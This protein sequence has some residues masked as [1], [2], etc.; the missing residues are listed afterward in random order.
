MFSSTSYKKLVKNKW[1]VLLVVLALALMA[2]QLFKKVLNRAPHEGFTQDSP[3]VSKHNADIYDSYYAMIYD[4]IYK[5][6]Q[7]VAY[8][9]Q[10]IIDMTHPSPGNSVF[11]DVGSGTGALVNE[12]TAQGYEAHG[13]DKSQAM[14][15]VA[16]IKYPDAA[17]N[18]KCG[19]AK[20]SMSFDRASFTHITCM[21][22]TLYEMDSESRATFFRNCYHWLVPN[23]YL[24]IHLVDRDT[25]SPIVPGAIPPTIENPQKYAKK[26]ITDSAIDFYDFKYKNSTKF[27][28]NGEVLIKE[29]F[30]DAKNG[31]IRENEM[32]LK[33]DSMKDIMFLAQ[34]CGFIPHSQ[35][36]YTTDENQ[37]IVI[38]EKIQ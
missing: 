29:T 2:G 32:I 26:R 25:Y 27:E 33:M 5:P 31:N 20:D 28:K 16:Q 7:R 24:I 3:F 4:D 6:K 13:I 36:T 14:V 21:N 11:L 9:Y 18:I 15:D 34:R 23:G 30:K 37:Y 17:S 35:S 19:D 12:L 22:F 10:K 1:F 38:L 8:E